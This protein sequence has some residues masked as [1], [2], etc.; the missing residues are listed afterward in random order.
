MFSLKKRIIA[1]ILSFIACVIHPGWAVIF[2]T[3]LIALAH[4]CYVESKYKKGSYYKD[5]HLPYKV[6]KADSGRYGEYLIYKNLQHREGPDGKF[7]FNAYIPTGEGNT[8]EIDVMFLCRKGIFV[9]ESKNY[10]G[11]IFGKE[12]QQN[13]TQ[14][15]PKG[16]K[17]HKEHFYNPIRQNAGHINNLKRFA[18]ETA[19]FYSV[20]AFSDRCTI[21]AME[22]HSQ[23]VFVLHRR[24][25]ENPIAAVYEY[26]EDI[27]TQDELEALYATLY[28]FTQA[29]EEVKSNHVDNIQQTRR[30]SIPVTPIES[31][32]NSEA[33]MESELKIAEQQQLATEDSLES[34]EKAIC[35][36]CQGKLVLRTA[37]RGDRAGKRFYGCENY[38][39]CK[40]IKNL[41]E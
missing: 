37:R 11:W 26:C 8:T 38:P 41:N 30:E 40:Y 13:W 35:P 18:N 3:A 17:S 9:F 33:D 21:K 14:T 31:S 22:V 28:P 6:M 32:M 4:E 5:T 27:M 12:S 34:A 29:S 10:S 15:L 16:R 23:N 7:L 2:C 24:E 36:W 25:V 39:K 19:R 20:I 1:V